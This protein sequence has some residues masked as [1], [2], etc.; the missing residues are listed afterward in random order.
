MPVLFYARVKEGVNYPEG[1]E[2]LPT[3]HYKIKPHILFKGEELK[4]CP[5]CNEWLVLSAFHVCNWLWDGKQP[6][7]RLCH[8]EATAE[9]Y[10]RRTRK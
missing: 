8:G 10:A 2:V 7:C 9:D 6:L 4:H 1:A 3:D 5:V